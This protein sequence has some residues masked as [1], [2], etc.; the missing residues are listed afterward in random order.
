MAVAE[1]STWLEVPGIPVRAEMP[2]ADTAYA[3]CPKPTHV[4][5]G[6]IEGVK[7]CPWNICG[8][9]VPNRNVY[10]PEQTEFMGQNK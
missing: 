5:H 1:V 7:V 4:E 9:P 2:P 6:V 8:N 10:S 3:V